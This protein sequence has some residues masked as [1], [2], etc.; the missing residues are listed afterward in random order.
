MITHAETIDD[1]RAVRI[2]WQDGAEARFHAFWLYDNDPGPA[3]RDPGNGQ[4]LITVDEVPKDAVL[5]SAAVKDGAL[6]VVFSDGRTVHFDDAWMKRHIYDHPTPD[7]VL[8]EGIE[9]WRADL[10]D[11]LSVHEYDAVVADPAAKRDWLADVRRWG[12]ARL[13][14]MPITPGA[15]ADVAR[16]F[17]FVRETNYGPVFQVRAEVSPSNLAYTNAGLQAHTDNPYRDPAPTLQLLACLENT[18]TGG[19]S[20][21]VD[22]FRAARVLREESPED[23]QRLAGYPARFAYTGQAGV[24]LHA[25]RPMIE[26]GP[27]GTLTHIRFNSRSVAPLTDIPYDAMPDYY[28]AYRHFSAIIDRAD[29]QVAFRL[30]PGEMFILDNRRVLHARTAFDGGGNRL[31]EGCYADVDGLYSTLLALEAET[32]DAAA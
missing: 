26:R 17:G 1:G 14:G 30:E 11:R 2:R 8:P 16:L 20:T 18:V 10:A 6:A 13:S 12:V 22:G 28:R 23:F 27:D 3:V 31:L 25:K 4:R 15:V 7:A 5:D 19:F 24:R 21:V 9:T 32:G 29:M